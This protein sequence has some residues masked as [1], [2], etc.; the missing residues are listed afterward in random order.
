MTCDIVHVRTRPVV[1]AH[2][3][4]TLEVGRGRGRRGKERGWDALRMTRSK[5]G[6]GGEEVLGLRWVMLPRPLASPSS[7]P[8]RSSLALHLH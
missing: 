1:M 5:R 4:L 7:S 8:H 6:G 3:P 2:G